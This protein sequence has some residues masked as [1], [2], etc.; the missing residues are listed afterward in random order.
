MTRSLL[1]DAQLENDQLFPDDVRLAG[2]KHLEENGVEHE[3]KVYPDVPHG[4]SLCI[5]ALSLQP[6]IG[7]CELVFVTEQMS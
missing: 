5:T 2:Q 3:I 6:L 7:S 4:E 1:N